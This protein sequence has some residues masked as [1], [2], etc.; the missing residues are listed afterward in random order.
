MSE[1]SRLL[2]WEAQSSSEA[3]PARRPAAA[4]NGW[5]HKGLSSLWDGGEAFE[6]VGLERVGFPR[7]AVPLAVLV[8]DYLHRNDDAVAAKLVGG[9]DTVVE[10]SIGSNG[11]LDG[12][13]Q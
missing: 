10:F 1:R 7:E 8:S 2:K 3:G 11:E 5:P 13:R 12:P 9:S 4:N 6:R